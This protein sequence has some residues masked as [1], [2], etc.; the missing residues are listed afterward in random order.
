MGGRKASGAGSGCRAATPT[1]SR[2][3]WVLSAPSRPSS[4]VAVPPGTRCQHCSTVTA[5]RRLRS[6]D[7]E[8]GRWPT[9][10]AATASVRCPPVKVRPRRSLTF[11]A[12]VALL[13][14]GVLAACSTST[15]EGS[16]L[17]NSGGSGAKSGAASDH[18][19]KDTSGTEVPA[20]VGEDLQP[21][22][23]KAFYVPP[24]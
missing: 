8:S 4:E 21:Y 10:A 6:T 5:T 14:A 17:G 22:T 15:G 7:P 18:G 3:A 1:R 23:G 11:V 19:S 24:D 20:V 2:S 9:W 12:P 13:L 16:P